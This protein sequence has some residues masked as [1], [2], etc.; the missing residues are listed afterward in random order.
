M[1]VEELRDYCVAKPG[2]SESLPF[3]EDT[4]VFKVGSKIFALFGVSD[5]PLTINLKCD[6]EKAISLREEYD[7]VKPGYHM[8]KRLWNTVTVNQVKAKLVCEW[9]DHSY[10]LVVESLPKKI[11]SELS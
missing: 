1:N 7:A 10:D 8:N 6:P 4:L 11:K 2:A 3:D 9:I 5:S